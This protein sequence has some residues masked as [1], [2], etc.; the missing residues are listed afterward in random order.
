MTTIEEIFKI[1]DLKPPFCGD[2]DL[3]SFC[4]ILTEPGLVPTNIAKKYIEKYF[5][6]ITK[7]FA[8]AAKIHNEIKEAEKKY[9]ESKK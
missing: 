1:K 4:D 2:E 5:F 7:K 6:V 3:N 8:E 9:Y